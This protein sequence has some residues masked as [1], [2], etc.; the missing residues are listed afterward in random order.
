MRCPQCGFNAEDLAAF[1]SRCGARLH[2]PQPAAQREFALI[3]IFPSWWR[4]TGSFV[5]AALLFAGAIVMAAKG[6]RRE[7]AVAIALSFVVAI[8]AILVRRSTSWSI[9]SERLIENRGLLLSR[10]REIELADIRSVEVNRRLIQR[11]LGLGNVLAASA[12]SADFLI[13]L[14]DVV[15]P[16]DIAEMLRKARLKRL[17]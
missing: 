15:N 7:A 11:L 4:F 16:D 6:L 12:A 17:A 9:T 1:C 5:V 8:I 10:R 3:R 2:A 14:E 13:R